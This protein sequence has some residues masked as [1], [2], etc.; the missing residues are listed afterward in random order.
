MIPQKVESS[1]VNWQPFVQLIFCRSRNDRKLVLWILGNAALRSDSWSFECWH[2]LSGKWKLVL[3]MPDCQAVSSTTMPS[4]SP[5]PSLRVFPFPANIFFCWP[6]WIRYVTWC[7]SH[8]ATLIK[9]LRKK[10]PSLI[11]TSQNISWF[12]FPVLASRGMEKGSS[13]INMK[14]KI[15]EVTHLYCQKVFVVPEQRPLSRRR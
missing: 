13:C 3:W 6:V 12:Y 10:N 4:S 14:T 1:R 15:A 2:C 5:P 11:I 7:K 8:W 9:F